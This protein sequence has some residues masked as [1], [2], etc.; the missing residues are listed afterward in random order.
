METS[1]SRVPA[2]SVR[3]AATAPGRVLSLSGASLP[4]CSLVMVPAPL[5]PSTVAYAFASAR[6]WRWKT[7]PLGQA[8]V[9]GRACSRQ[10]LVAGATLR[11]IAREGW[12]STEVAL[13]GHHVLGVCE[14]GRVHGLAV[15]VV[16]P[17]DGG[18]PRRCME[19]R[20]LATLQHVV[21]PRERR[22]LYLRA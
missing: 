6:C 1:I 12:F 9:L 2:A 14:G 8:E 20:Q 15:R 10:V 4:G 11:D 17:S 19:P 21:C 13:E 5:S 16:D 22:Q 3:F 18:G 7:P